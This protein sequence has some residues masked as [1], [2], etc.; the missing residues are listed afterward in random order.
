MDTTAIIIVA[1]T[2]TGN[3]AGWVTTLVFASRNHSK[4]QGKY[5]QKLNNLKEEVDELSCKSNPSFQLDMGAM[6]QNQLDTNRR[7]G[8]IEEKLFNGD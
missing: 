3:I 5:E 2:L 8:R 7:L 6:I 1:V 4:Q